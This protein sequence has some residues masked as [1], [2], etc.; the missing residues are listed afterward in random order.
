MI[1][2]YLWGMVGIFVVGTKV[3]ITWKNLLDLYLGLEFNTIAAVRVT[4]ENSWY[5]R[6]FILLIMRNVRCLPDCNSLQLSFSNET[7]LRYSF[8]YDIASLQTIKAFYCL[9]HQ[10]WSLLPGS[11]PYVIFLYFF[12][13][14]SLI[15]PTATISSITLDHTW[16]LVNSLPFPD[17]MFLL[18]LPAIQP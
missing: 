3:M 17:T 1:L 16:Q 8:H 5:A 2:F 11:R 13:L 10:I 12:I 18:Y 9:Q 4:P 7:S 14:C 6:L 15:F